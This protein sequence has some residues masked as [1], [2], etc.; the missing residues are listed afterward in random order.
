MS[1]VLRN[2]VP[3]VCC[4]VTCCR[5]VWLLQ[6]VGT[7]C[8]RALETSPHPVFPTATQRTLT[9]SG[10]FLS[11]PERRRVMTKRVK[12]SVQSDSLAE[13]IKVTDLMNVSVYYNHSL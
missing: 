1:S 2:V 6:D 11:P 8:R 9:V 12:A 13:V 7:V 10:R 5:G 3:L 4:S